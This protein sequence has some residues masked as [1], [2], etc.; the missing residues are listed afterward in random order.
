P[1]A[2]PH[3]FLFDRERKL[4]YEGRIDN[5]PREALVTKH[6]ARDAL[7]AMLADKQVAVEHMPA[8]GCSTKWAYKEKGTRDEL[9]QAAK[10]PVRLDLTSADQLKTLRKNGTGKLILVNF[11][12]TWCAPCTAEFPEIQKMV[13]MYRKRQLQIVTVSINAPDEKPMVQKFLDEQHAINTNLLWN[14]NDSA[15]AVAA[16]GTNWSGGV[17]Y[18]VL[19]G[20]DGE[21][22][23]RSQG[24]MDPLEVK[25]V[26]LKHLPD[27]NYKGQQAYW[28][29]TF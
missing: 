29:S 23:Y 1:T 10:E 26:I 18:T 7:D 13:R 19:I 3:I 14:T 21:T 28:N 4:R 12:A 15:E 16:F 9:A 2:T 5:N 11:W 17:P 25:R 8:V 20:M 24:A 6:E 22:L 27:D